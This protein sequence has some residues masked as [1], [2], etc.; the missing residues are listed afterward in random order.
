MMLWSLTAPLEGKDPGVPAKTG[1]LVARVI[2]AAKGSKGRQ[3]EM[4]SSHTGSTRHSGERGLP[5]MVQC[6][7]HALRLS[8]ESGNPVSRAYA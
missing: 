3:R 6:R 7:N 5:K 1:G 4:D 2:A 8:R